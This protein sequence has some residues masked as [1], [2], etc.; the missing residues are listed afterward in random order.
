MAITDLKTDVPEYS[1][2]YNIM[3]LCVESDNIALPE[4]K[5]IFDVVTETLG[6]ERFKVVP[7]PVTGLQLG[8]KDIGQILEGFIDERIAQFNS[9]GTFVFGL[10]R[11]II[12]F[13]IEYGEEYEVGGVLTQFPDLL[14]GTDKFAWDAS[15]PKHDWIDEHNDANPFNTWLMNQANGTNGEFLTSYKTPKVRLLDLG[16]H[17][18]INDVPGDVDYLEVKTFDSAGVLIQTVQSVNPVTTVPTA[19]RL[20]SVTTGPQSL[21]NIGP[22][23]QLGS[24]PIIDSTVATYTIQ[25]FESTPTA[26][27]ELLT[28]TI[29]EGCRYEIFR[30]HFLNIYGGF[31]SF[32]FTS[33]SLK[34]SISSK[35]SYTRSKT[36]ITADGVQ[37]KHEDNGTVDYF[38]KKRN[39]IRLQS[40]YLTNEENTWLEQLINSPHILLQF[41]DKSGVPNFKQVKM[42]TNNWRDQDI[43][44]DKLFRLTIEIDIAQEDF[45]QRR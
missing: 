34:T 15:F 39:K 37:F 45:S 30:L 18:L 13:H 2:V 14:T 17:W 7:E 41:L 20:L 3:E 22:A 25:I 23:L 16:W 38:I 24:Q 32:N 43:S 19:A 36:D 27:S 5:Y 31:D 33:R 1:P 6:S 8:I 28:F 21:N 35:K 10:D 42:V 11:P 4:F 12:K 29:D 44:I 9:T 40:D 26:I